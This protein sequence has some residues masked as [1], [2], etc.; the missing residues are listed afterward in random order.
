M[1]GPG[2]NDSLK[3]T[4]L[5]DGLGQQ[6]QPLVHGHFYSTILKK[7]PEKVGVYSLGN[8][9]MTCIE[10]VLPLIQSR[11]WKISMD[12]SPKGSTASKDPCPSSISHPRGEAWSWAGRMWMLLRPDV[13]RA[14]WAV[15]PL[16][17][18]LQL[19]YSVLPS[20]APAKPASQQCL[21]RALLAGTNCSSM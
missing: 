19:V 20:W 13:L 10:L 14:S 18:P 12:P 21:P 1:R 2:E 4:Q 16:G 8:T 9:E 7:Q 3:T 5:V 15:C 11:T 6:L 17:L